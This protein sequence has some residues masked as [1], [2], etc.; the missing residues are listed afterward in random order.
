MGEIQAS[1]GNY[2]LSIKYGLLAIKIAEK[3]GNHSLLLSSTYNHI[4]QTYYM[5]KD[6]D[7]A[8]LYWEKAAQTAGKFNNAGYMQIILTN[9][10]M[11]S[12]RQHK[13]Q[14][15]LIF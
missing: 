10:A 11:L 5:L 12:I 8:A 7:K 6:D 3:T 4:G 14:K 9:L 13:Y 1:L 2:N 15:A